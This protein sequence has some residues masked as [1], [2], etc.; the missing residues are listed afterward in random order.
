MI[1]WLS[2]G[3]INIARYVTPVL[4]LTDVFIWFLLVRKNTNIRKNRKVMIK[5]GIISLVGAALAPL[6]IVLVSGNL[7]PFLSGSWKVIQNIDSFSTFKNVLSVVFKG[8]SITGGIF[9]LSIVFLFFVKDAK[10][11]T[12]AVLYPF[13]LFAALTRINCFLEG[14]CFGK[15]YDG[16]FALSYP[17]ASFASKHHFAKYGLPSRY[18]ASLPVY[19]TPIYII[20]SMLFLFC[21]ILLMK[22]FKVKKNIIAGTVLAGYGSINFI[23]EFFREEPLVFKFV[24]M[25]QIMEFILFF[26]GLYVIFKVKEEEISESGN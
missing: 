6:F 15:L 12:F 25:G 22:K 21:V 9:I 17:P 14:C 4:F 23:I 24:T 16:I 5:A 11:L 2:G 10:K 19:P 18:V 1:N 3:V 7:F 8:F 20:F 13:P 26:I